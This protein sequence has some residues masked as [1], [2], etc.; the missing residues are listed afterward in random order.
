MAGFGIWVGTDRELVGLDPAGSRSSVN[1]PIGLAIDVSSGARSPLLAPH[2]DRRPN[3]VVQTAAANRSTVVVGGTRCASF[4]LDES[5]A[6]SAG[7]SL[8]WDRRG[9]WSRLRLPSEALDISHLLVDQAGD[10]YAVLRHRSASTGLAKLDGERWIEIA[11]WPGA[12]DVSVCL[13]DTRAF[14]LQ[15]TYDPLAGDG[16]STVDSVPDGL[17]PASFRFTGI[18]LATGGS[19]VI[20]TPDLLGDF[21][22]VGVLLGC[23]D[24]SP[25]LATQTSGRGPAKVYVLRS[26]RWEDLAPVAGGRPVMLAE[27]VNRPG[28]VIFTYVSAEEGSSEESVR[29]VRVGGGELE[30]VGGD[31]IE[32]RLVPMGESD[33]VAVVSLS[34]SRPA[35]VIEVER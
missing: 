20:A 6:C 27:A 9:G 7:I 30:E 10:F 29:A 34:G 4:D 1:D 2:D 23:S 5:T 3:L 18:D 28:D 11:S 16:P 8:R 15:R 22:G 19:S 31:Y 13:T 25:V 14:I 32:R 33:R 24:G 17:P 35:S 26:A 21:G 12:E